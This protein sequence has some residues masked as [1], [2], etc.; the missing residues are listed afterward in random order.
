MSEQQTANVDINQIL[1]E[2]NQ[3]AHQLQNPRVIELKNFIHNLGLEQA[4]AI[5][6]KSMETN[7]HPNV[8]YLVFTNLASLLHPNIPP[9]LLQNLLNSLLPMAITVNVRVIKIALFRC[10]SLSFYHL[11]SPETLPIVKP[12]ISQLGE[13]VVIFLSELTHV[14]NQALD[15]PMQSQKNFE[16]LVNIF[17]EYFPI[18]IDQFF[19][20][21]SINNYD[22]LNFYLTKL[23]KPAIEALTAMFEN[24]TPFDVNSFVSQIQNI[25]NSKITGI[26][27]VF[28]NNATINDSRTNVLKFFSDSV[29]YGIDPANVLTILNAFLSAPVDLGIV[30]SMC[31][32][33][34]RVFISIPQVFN[35]ITFN[36]LAGVCL[37]LAKNYCLDELD[38]ALNTLSYIF[39][40]LY[41]MAMTPSDPKFAELIKQLLQL[42]IRPH[43]SS[44]APKNS[45][46]N[47]GGN[48]GENSEEESDNEFEDD[49]REIENEKRENIIENLVFLTR[50]NP[51]PSLQIVSEAF[52]AHVDCYASEWVLMLLNQFLQLFTDFENEEVL[53][54]TATILTNILASSVIGNFATSSPMIASLI[55]DS[56]IKLP[57]NN[58]GI[59]AFHLAMSV[60]PSCDFVMEK[61]IVLAMRYKFTM[62]QIPRNAPL[63][64]KILSLIVKLAPTPSVV[65]WINNLMNS[66]NLNDL[67]VAASLIF[68]LQRAN[69]EFD[70][71][72]YALAL[73]QKELF[74][75]A[76]KIS[77]KDPVACSQIIDAASQHHYETDVQQ[78]IILNAIRS[79]TEIC[80]GPLTEKVLLFANLTGNTDMKI[81]NSIS[82][83]FLQHKENIIMRISEA[84]LT[85]QSL[86]ILKNLL[87]NLITYELTPYNL[88]SQLFTSLLFSF[89]RIFP[90][91]DDEFWLLAMKYM[92]EHDPSILSDSPDI[93]FQ[94]ANADFERYKKLMFTV[95]SQVTDTAAPL[96][97]YLHDK[98]DQDTPEKRR[99]YSSKLYCVYKAYAYYRSFV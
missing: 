52:N 37:E 51:I 62:D 19:A 10:I 9:A 22:I 57:V 76:L 73:Y 8:Q 87:Q 64:P 34:R 60:Y 58:E 78:R 18:V 99:L 70:S 75:E 27:P 79:A 4:L 25:L 66:P 72:P 88:L 92:M 7:S 69:I 21:P 32:M 20:N 71:T 42:L 40:K 74:A 53:N 63:S 65:E 38:T 81:F 29:N 67:Q 6:S 31:E 5:C 26:I 2:M 49:E 91:L 45:I 15:V 30:Q 1:N 12:M 11:L 84:N 94:F 24:P 86:F 93:L 47:N 59:K 56:F 68:G 44:L 97:D 55:C 16:I 96:M 28:L 39:A 61:A 35:D 46:D 43:P 95:I 83:L 33:I 48:N 89:E 23:Q 41:D 14:L 77:R 17:P 36:Y 50:D 13:S 85:D 90:M 54:V 98:I 3:L 82:K 80:F